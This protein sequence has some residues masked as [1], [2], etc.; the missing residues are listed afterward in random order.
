MTVREIRADDR[1]RL[2]EIQQAVLS[3]PSPSVL[4]AA[5]DGPLFGLVAEDSGAVVGY[6]L[7]VIGETRTYVP[8]LAVAADTQRRGHGSALLAAAIDRL[9]ERSVRTVRLTTRA[10]DP[11]A[12]AFYEQ[13]GFESVERI[14]DHY[15]DADGV[16]Y[17]R[18]IDG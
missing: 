11:A 7:A 18:R 1:D 4:A 6:L 10:D 14:P 17:E 2:R 8:E 16:V 12:R 9:C 5:L 13:Q 3:D 15:D